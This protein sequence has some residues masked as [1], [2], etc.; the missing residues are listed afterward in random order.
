MA[1]RIS[2][3]F[4]YIQRPAFQLCRSY[5]AQ[6]AADV[7]AELTAAIKS[8]MKSK[9]TQTS[10]TLRGVLAEIHSADKTVNQPIDSSAIYSIVKKAAARRTDAAAQYTAAGR[11]ELAEK[12]TAEATLLS[13]FLP[14]VLSEAE[15]DSILQNIL[16][17]T[18]DPQKK[19]GNIFKVFYGTVDKST[20][21]SDMVKRRL[22]VLLGTPN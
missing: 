21:D 19:P 8:A 4:R 15:V 13:Q 6:A 18:E 9:D 20:V 3:S 22:F 2:A 16:A 11:P 14:P 7:R 5:S 1:A 10:I 17:V 12:E